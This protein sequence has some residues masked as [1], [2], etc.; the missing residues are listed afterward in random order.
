MRGYKSQ[1]RKRNYI[2]HASMKRRSDSPC[3]SFFKCST[4][5]H[6]STISFMVQHVCLIRN[7]DIMS[8]PSLSQITLLES[9]N[10]NYDE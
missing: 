8:L 9:G 7:R 2:K 3:S 4:F 1:N 6:A 10:A 5:P